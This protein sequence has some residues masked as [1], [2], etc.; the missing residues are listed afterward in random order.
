MSNPDR[1]PNR[2]AAESSPYL[3][4]HAHNPVDW[5]PWGPEAFEKAR[6]EGKPVFLSIGYSSCH[7]CHVMERES[8]ESEE[9]ARVL[10]E[11]FV[12]VKVDREERP[13]VD[14]VYI[15]AVQLIVGRGGWPLS[16]FLFP[17]GRPFFGGTYFPPDDR[18]GRAGFRTLL[19]RLHEAWTHRRDELEE[20]AE[21]ILAEVRDGA[22]LTERLGERPL[23]AALGDALTA[24]LKRSLDARRGGFGGAPKFPPH[25]A[26]TWLLKKGREGDRTAESAALLTLDAMALGG[27]HDHLGGGF[28]RY[29]TDGEWLL[30]HFE[31]M[32]SDNAQLLG[33]YAAAFARTGRGLH[34]RAA[35]GIGDYL[36][37]EMRGPEGAFFAATDADSEG[38]EGRYFVWSEAE[39]RDVLASDAAFF[40]ERYQV[41]PEGNFRDEASG[42]PTGQNVLHLVE[43]PSDEEE[44]RLAPLRAKLKARRDRRVAPGLDD[45]RIAGW[46]ALAVSGLAIASKHLAEPRYLEAARG[47]ARFLL[48]TCRDGSGRLLRTCKDGAGKVPGFLEDEAYLALALLD[49]A[50]AEADEGERT[51]WLSEA[52]RTVDGLRRRFG[53]GRRPGFAF[54]GEGHEA[55][56]AE[57]RDLFDKAIPSAPG[58]AAW[59]LVRLALA[60][61]DLSLAVEAKEALAEASGLMARAPHGTESWHLALADLLELE[62][63]HGPLSRPR[64]VAAGRTA[65]AAEVTSGPVAV[66]AEAAPASLRRGEPTEVTVTVTV[67]PGAYLSGEQ[68]LAVEVRGGADLPVETAVPASATFVEHDDGTAEAGYRGTVR[69]RFVLRASGAAALGRRPVSVLVRF[70]ACRERVCE[71]ERVAALDLGVEVVA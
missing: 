57:G 24:A 40:A 9:T 37:R 59:A 68:G 61:S 3:R 69:S 62:R 58:A 26:L 13:D 16:A 27:I 38:E 56:V 42:R 18:G 21:R 43:E 49:L 19:L 66:R 33:A 15:A 25:L 52:R 29:S 14:D 31:K 44:R 47:T 70:R 63:R 50:D 8:F 10:N 28:H 55:L 45:K 22:R 64:H 23:D 5:F 20:T 36:L 12:S 65:E 11:R 1:R 67:E 35:R 17:D 7:W 2:L 60:D 30:P 6:R 54:T 51:R 4:Q 34:R 71:P 41:R 46:N 39:V 32:L 48:E 53:R